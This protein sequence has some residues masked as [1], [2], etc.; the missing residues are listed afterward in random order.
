MRTILVK[1]NQRTSAT[2]ALVQQ[3]VQMLC[4]RV[5]E[6]LDTSRIDRFIHD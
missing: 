1:E 3:V 4:L 5:W 6:R 2:H